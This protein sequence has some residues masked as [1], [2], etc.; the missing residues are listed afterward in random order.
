MQI[1]EIILTL[2]N[3][4]KK[5]LVV[6][7]QIDVPT[8]ARPI[9][10]YMRTPAGEAFMANSNDCMFVTTVFGHRLTE[11][12]SRADEDLVRELAQEP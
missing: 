10:F 1:S 4:I 5:G 3:L 7:G 12:K 2:R 8:R 11:T 6:G 9:K